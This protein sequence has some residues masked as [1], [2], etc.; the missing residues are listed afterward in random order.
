[1]KG[2]K[3]IFIATFN[4]QTLQKEWKIPEL[5]S[6]AESTKHDIICLQEHR[7]MHDDLVTKEHDFGNWKLITCSAWKN[8]MNAST[9]G[10]AML[11]SPQAYNALS[12]VEKISPRIMVATFNGNPQTT[13]ISCYSPTNVSNEDEVESFYHEL[14]SLT[15][16]VPKHNILILGGDFN[17][18]LGQADSFK[19]AYHLQTNRNGE[20]LKDFLNENK[21]L[22]LN[23][24]Y[25]KRTGQLWT[26]KA[27]NGV[28][29]QLDY[30][31]INRKWKNSAKN[32]RAFNSFIT[33]G[34]DHR[35]V[36]A[37]I[38]LSLR[39]NKKKSSSNPPYDWSYLKKNTEV[40]NN[41]VISVKNRFAALQEANA[42]NNT[43]NT[44]YN[45]VVLA[46]KEAALDTIPLKPKIKKHKPWETEAVCLKRKEL[47]DAAQMKNSIPSDENSTNFSNA[48]SALTE[49]Y[50]K[51]QIE[52]LQK[53]VDTIKDA[54]SNKKSAIAWKTVNE[55]SGRKSTNKA[56][57][58]ASSQDE[59]LK[60]W[61]NH[62]QDL[63]GKPPV[64]KE[65]R[66]APVITVQLNIKT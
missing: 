56:K 5:I 32:C 62:F 61:Q 30:I 29:A 59:R 38:R 21:L 8:S 33:V 65:E 14:S 16:Q 47:L 37:K 40:G 11:I 50:Q 46:C 49:T 54:T 22:C 42:T 20:M 35:I 43:A 57:L 10:V 15:R 60:L 55:I 27:P 41:F 63:L 17:A 45:N 12:S 26:H 31:I 48:R 6:S 52:Y 13:V 7:F 25:Q 28:K 18:H 1:M 9:G 66:I 3:D 39:A 2:K 4:V 58:K 53:K 23:I 51:E 34:S 64:I 36:S 24:N 44:T 19:Y